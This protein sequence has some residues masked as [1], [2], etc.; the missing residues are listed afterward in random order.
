MRESNKYLFATAAIISLYLSFIFVA[1]TVNTARALDLCF[2]AE[3][4]SCLSN[5][6]EVVQSYC[7]VCQAR[8]TQNRGIKLFFSDYPKLEWKQIF[9]NLLFWVIQRLRNNNCEITVKCLETA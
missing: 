5:G 2:L 6:D 9:L 3:G 4:E 8:S 7:E 1:H